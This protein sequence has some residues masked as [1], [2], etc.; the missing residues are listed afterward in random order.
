MEA[1]VGALSRPVPHRLPLRRQLCVRVGVLRDG[2]GQARFPFLR[3]F[4][5]RAVVLNSFIG[6]LSEIYV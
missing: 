2:T 1:E 5:V 3:Q 4:C 6:N